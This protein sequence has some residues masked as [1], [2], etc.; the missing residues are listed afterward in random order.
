MR[1]RKRKS[2]S[3]SIFTISVPR[4]LLSPSPSLSLRDLRLCCAHIPSNQHSI[5]LVIPIFLT[6]LLFNLRYL[7]ASSTLS[8]RERAT[9]LQT[10]SPTPNSKPITNKS[11]ATRYQST[12][13]G[14]SGGEEGSEE[15]EDASEEELEEEEEQQE[16]EHNGSSH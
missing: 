3:S 7:V 9:I 10:F 15:E 6:H 1:A 13:V 12:D 5:A 8:A 16:G 14:E 11:H 2:K 4:I